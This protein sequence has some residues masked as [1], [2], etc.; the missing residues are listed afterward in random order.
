MEAEKVLEDY[1]FRNEGSLDQ[2]DIEVSLHNKLHEACRL[3]ENYWKIKSRNPWLQEGDKNT[4]FFH[5]QAKIRKH[6]KTVS[7]IDHL[8]N[9]LSAFDEIKKAAHDHFQ[10]I[11]I[12]KSPGMDF[13][14]SDILDNIPPLVSGRSNRLLLLLV[15]L[16]EV[17]FFVD[18]MS[19]DK[20]PGLDGFTAHF[21]T[22]CW[23]LIHNVLFQLVKKSQSCVKLGG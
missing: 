9:Q 23:H 21:L 6:F 8:G 4:K 10:E 1:H 7:K 2:L 19:P 12:E 16:E 18:N 22:S 17:K 5:K 15:S 13:S 11:Y 14:H 20:A 3:E